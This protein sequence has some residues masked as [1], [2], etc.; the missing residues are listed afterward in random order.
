MAA[1][2]EK[3]EA[4]YKSLTRKIVLIVVVASA[5]PLILISGTIRYYFQASYQDKVRE[6]L[7]VL[8]KKQSAKYRHLPK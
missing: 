7:K 1:R 8:I 2:Q 6:H 3:G 4:Y 5:I